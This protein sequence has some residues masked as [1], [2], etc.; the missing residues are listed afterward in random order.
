MN[1]HLHLVRSNRLELQLSY[2]HL[3]FDL[4]SYYFKKGEKYYYN[5]L[6]NKVSDIVFRQVYYEI[7]TG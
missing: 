5:Y 4:L 6:G 2:G 1:V 7:Y 3:S